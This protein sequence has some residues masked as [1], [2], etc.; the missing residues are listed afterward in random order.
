[1]N[2]KPLISVITVSYNAVLTIEQTILS[3]IDQ[4]YPNIEYIIIDGGSKDTTIDIIKKYSDQISYWKS[5]PDKGIYDAM[6]KG[7]AIARGEWINFMN[8][9]DT[10]YNNHVIEDLMNKAN[11]LSDIIYGDTNLIL[12]IG[13]YIEKG[14]ETTENEYMSFGHQAA[15]SRTSLMKKHGFDL[16]YRICAD[17]N[18]FYLVH[19]EGAKFEY[20]DLIV[21][22]YEAEI[23][24]SS[25]NMNIIEYEKGMIE[26]K[27]KE[28]FWNIRFFIYSH[29]YT[30]KEWSKSVLPQKILDAIKK[31]N[32]KKHLIPNKKYLKI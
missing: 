23:G 25:S 14:Q 31:R 4:T 1:M 6:N 30:F 13:E 16:K 7:I 24:L 18:F 11:R 32:A 5:E 28:L 3:V 15:F 29:L 19:K 10:F 2:S 9:G 21:A 17:R 22:N 27:N 12:S 26:G 20:I 8:C